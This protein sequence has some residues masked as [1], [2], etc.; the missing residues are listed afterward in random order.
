VAVL[1]FILGFLGARIKSDVRI[2]EQVY[3]MISIFLLFG[4]GLK[5][6]HALKGTSLS[7]FAAPSNCDNSSRNPYPSYCISDFKVCKEN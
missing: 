3:Q 5:G 1:V 7:S 6:G 2:P 4:I